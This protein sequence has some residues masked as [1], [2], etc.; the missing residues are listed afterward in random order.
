[1][2]NALVML[3]MPALGAWAD[4]HG[5]KKRLLVISTVG[6]V[7]ATAALV[8]VQPGALVLAMVLIAISSLC[9]AWGDSLIAAFLPELARPQA[10]SRV[11]GWGWSWSFGYLGGMLALG[12]SLAYVIW[13][14]GQGQGASQFVLVTMLITAGIFA[15]AALVTLWL[16]R[17]RAVANPQVGCHGVVDAL[18]QLQRTFDNAKQYTDYMWLLALRRGLP[19]GVWRSPSRWQRSTPSR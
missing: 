6:C 5:A 4:R 9:F 2:S 15:A 3:T 1:V 10:M 13:A 12:L 11:S 18:R 8:W 7:L 19:E 14:Q 17:E 16:L